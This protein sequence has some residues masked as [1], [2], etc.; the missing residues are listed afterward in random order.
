MFSAAG[1]GAV[2]WNVFAG[3]K[4]LRSAISPAIASAADIASRAIVARAASG[5]GV[6]TTTSGVSMR[7]A[8]SASAVATWAGYTVAFDFSVAPAPEDRQMVVPM[9]DRRMEVDQ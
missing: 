8:V 6:C 9:D 1:T 2:S 7:Y 4:L 3:K 5:A